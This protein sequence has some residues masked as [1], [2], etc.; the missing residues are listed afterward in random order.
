MAKPMTITLKFGDRAVSARLRAGGQVSIADAAFTVAEA[1]SGLYVVDDGR[2]QW[3]VAVADSGEARWVSVDGQV[4]VVT[5]ETGAA[6]AVRK[7]SPAAGGM[8]APM[9]ATVVK[10]LVAPGQSVKDGET[11]LVLEAMKMELPIR[12][13]KAGVVKE[14]RCRQGEL[15]QPGEAL[16]EIA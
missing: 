14:V 10:V 3:E 1:G 9:P 8:T 2:R 12:A 11:V 13:P 16:V 5:V 4:L 15:V 6:R 7:K